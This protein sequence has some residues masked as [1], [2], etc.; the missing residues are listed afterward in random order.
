MRT[1]LITGAAGVVGRAVAAELRVDRVVGM[2][3]RNADAPEADTL[4][5][6]DLAAPR[7]GLTETAWRELAAEVDVI[8]HS[9]AL[10]EWGQ[11]VERY[12]AINVDGTA[13][14]VELAQRADAPVHFIS[15]CFVHAIER[16]R[17]GELGPGNIVTPYIQSKLASERVLA[18]SGV[19]HSIFRPTNLVGDSRTG[20]SS[21]PQIVQMLSDWVC[22]GKAPYFPIHPGN[23]VDIAPLD[24]LSRAVA[25]AVEA[26]DTGGPY[27]VTYGEAAMTVDVAIDVLV[28][29]ARSLG[30]EIERVPVVDPREPMPIA[31]E[32]I[33]PTS[34]AFL[35]VLIDVSEVTHACGGVLPSSLGKLAQRFGVPLASDVESYRLSLDY[36]AAE[37]ARAPYMMG[38]AA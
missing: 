32:R 19:P 17:V 20:A 34:R 21:S 36:W 5:V 13:R 3:H 31:L 33:A 11:P 38:D 30:R 2:V 29:H 7:L 27:W 1:T 15:T 14:V 18:D 28:E 10:T 8:V 35:K 23:L 4:V 25:A 22:R 12:D 9:G 16:G 37:R 26:D 24:V 6:G